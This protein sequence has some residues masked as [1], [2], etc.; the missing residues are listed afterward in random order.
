MGAVMPGK[1]R[2]HEP[3]AL[4]AP[5]SAIMPAREG[6][7]NSLL[8]DS[9]GSATEPPATDTPIL[10]KV[11]GF[12]GVDADFQ[13]DDVAAGKSAQAVTV[14][15]TIHFDPA[16]SGGSALEAIAAHEMAHVVQKQGGNGIKSDQKLSLE[17]EADQAAEGYFAGDHTA[18]STDTPS[19]ARCKAKNFDARKKLKDVSDKPSKEAASLIQ[20]LTAAYTTLQSIKNNYTDGIVW[21]PHSGL[22]RLEDNIRDGLTQIKLGDR[23]DP[24]DRSDFDYIRKLTVRQQKNTAG[25]SGKDKA[26]FAHTWIDN[27]SIESWLDWGKGVAKAGDQGKFKQIIEAG[28]LGAEWCSR[29][30][31]VAQGSVKFTMISN[32]DSAKIGMTGNKTQVVLEMIR[33]LAYRMPKNMLFGVRRFGQL[34]PPDSRDVPRIVD[35]GGKN[36]PT[37]PTRVMANFTG[38]TATI[39]ALNTASLIQLIKNVVTGAKSKTLEIPYSNV[40][41]YLDAYKVSLADLSLAKREPKSLINTFSTEPGFASGKTDLTSPMKESIDSKLGKVL[42]IRDKDVRVELTGHATSGGSQRTNERFANQRAAAARDHIAK[43]YT[44]PVGDM[45]INTKLRAPVADVKIAV[46]RA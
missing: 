23:K 39:R 7:S 29:Q 20:Q 19:A 27:Y 17:E 2:T 26:G 21:K 22:I 16:L 3:R 4:Q 43:K 10:S 6:D 25:Q 42:T 37:D 13:Y 34:L 44:K 30:D 32:V 5:A 36:G 31:Y 46:K 28:F 14:G 9:M 45:A 18:L 8:L 41:N 15:N 35:P 11:A 40:T 24:D 38:A 12:F 1:Q 33:E